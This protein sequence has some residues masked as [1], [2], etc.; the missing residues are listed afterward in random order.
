MEE[1]RE[2][3]AA[4]EEVMETVQAQAADTAAE[5]TEAVRETEA[6][7]ETAAAEAESAPARPEGPI[8]YKGNSEEEF[9]PYRPDSVLDNMSK[10][11]RIR[12]LIIVAILLA[13][14]FYKLA[15][16]GIAW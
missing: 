15:T 5:V 10:K 7:A 14:C 6:A 9:E 2:A 13:F 11:D 4:A 12:A 3:A 1:I 8:P 16:L